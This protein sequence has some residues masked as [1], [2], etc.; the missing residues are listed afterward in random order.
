MGGR[1]VGG[2]A[3]GVRRAVQSDVQRRGAARAW[4]PRAAPRGARR[5]ALGGVGPRRAALRAVAQ[6]LSAWGGGRWRR[7]APSGVWRRW[8]TL[9]GVG[10]RLAA[11]GDAGRR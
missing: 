9:G 11:P 6:C 10:C 7:V 2:A 1:G 8:A 3:L 4:R 5:F